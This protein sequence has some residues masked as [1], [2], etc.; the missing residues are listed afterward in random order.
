MTLTK[1]TN[2]MIQGANYSVLDFGARGDGVTDDYAAIQAA[3]DYAGAN[4]GGT[5]ELSKTSGK[6]VIS[7]GLKIPSYVTLT[8]TA[9]SSFPYNGAAASSQL[10]ANFT[11][12]NQWV[13]DCST[14]VSG[15]PVAYNAFVTGLPDGATFN[16]CVRDLQISSIGTMPYG[17]VRMQGCPGAVVENVSAVDTATGLLVNNCWSGKFR[18]HART[19]YYGVIVYGGAGANNFNIT[20]EQATVGGSL[21]ATVPSGYLM[22]FMNS[23]NGYMVPVLKLTTE[24]HY[25]RTWGLITAGTPDSLPNNNHFDIDIEQYSGGWFSYYGYSCTFDRFYFE[26]STSNMDFAIVTAYSSWIAQS[27]H[28]YIT[29]GTLFDLGTYNTIA[30]TPLGL[31]TYTSWGTGPYADVYSLMT[32]IG[33]GGDWGPSTPQFNMFYTSGSKSATISAFLN[34]WVNTGTPYQNCGYTLEKQTGTVNLHGGVSGGTASSVAFTLPLGYRPLY[35]KLFVVPGGAV[36]VDP[37]G[38][39]TI[40]SGTDVLLDSVY[41]EASP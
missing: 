39:V 4:G 35:R 31:Q 8:G 24:S 3:L 30:I 27:L 34:S 16:S 41:F 28:A 19:P 17:A 22:P 11:N 15:S 40:N 7:Q 5:V 14:T 37:N 9:M 10:V 21:P 6:Y 18:F 33:V 38:N 25:D 13:I 20:C 12:A 26:G 23:L 2:S 32:V 1:A 36:Q 29:T